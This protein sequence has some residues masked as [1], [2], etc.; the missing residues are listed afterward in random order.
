MSLP[1]VCAVLVTYHADPNTL[2]TAIKAVRPQVDALVIVENSPADAGAD[3]VT[4]HDAVVL[5]QQGNI[6]LAAAQNAGIAWAREHRHTH[7]LVLDHDSIPAADMVDVL[8]AAER[9]LSAHTKVA[10]VGPRF[11]DPREDR[12]APFV[13]VAFPRSRKIWCVGSNPYVR[14]DFLI[15]SGALISIAVLDEIGDMDDGLFID[16]VDMDWSFRARSKGFELY[17]VCAAAMRH[18]LG[19]AREPVLGGRA[20]V[21]RHGPQRLYYIMRNRVELY[22]RPYTPRV[23]IAQDVI[24]IPVKFLIFAVLVGPRLR[25]VR[26]MVRGLVDG[27][28]RRSGPCPIGRAA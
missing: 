11:H 19:D 2:R 24:R 4:G 14:C 7:V 8:L 13:R 28:R 22:R 5:P 12:D 16:N 26:Y 21:V 27:V 9:D 3:S 10:A 6:G 18:E 20:R 15:S 1:S 17:G 23:W 25:N